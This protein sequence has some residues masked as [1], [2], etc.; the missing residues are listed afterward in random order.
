MENQGTSLSW[1]PR[2]E[3]CQP[4]LT[5]PDR[6]GSTEEEEPAVRS[7]RVRRVG[8]IELLRNAEDFTA[9]VS[10]TPGEEVAM[11]EY[12]MAIMYASECVP[13]T[14]EAWRQWVEEEHS[15]EKAAIWLESRPPEH[16]DLFHPERP[17]GQNALLAPFM[18][19]GGVGSA[20]LVIERTGD[21]NQFFDKVHLHDPEPLPPDAAFRAMLTQHAYGLGGRAMA[22]ADWLGPQLTY[23]AVG[24]LGIRIRVLAR[25]RTL[26]DTLRLNIMPCKPDDVGTFNY[27]WTDGR[28][29]RRTFR[30]RKET[31]LPD[32]PADLHSFLGRSILLRPVLVNGKVM[33]DRV[34]RAAGEILDPLPDVHLQDAVLVAGRKGNPEP[35]RP[36][37]D[38]ALWRESHAVYAATYKAEEEV[39]KGMDL[40]GRLAVLGDRRVDLTAVGLISRQATA[41]AWVSDTFPYVPKWREELKWA[42]DEGSQICEY[43]AKCLYAAAVVARD[44][45]YPNPKPSD[46]AVFLKRLNAEPDLWAGAADHFWFLI[47]EVSGGTRAGK[48]PLAEFGREIHDLTW[49]LLRAR[50]AP[51]LAIPRGKSAGAE[52]E[53]R[54]KKMLASSSCPPYLKERPRV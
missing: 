24:R 51:L 30:G 9:L 42:A 25:G 35:L 28:V 33:V 4:V 45:A 20:Q 54:L 26:G 47:A 50:L 39:A 14:P 29:G 17:L 37:E 46:K 36:S 19:A 7:T 32:G 31:R 48:G 23:Q 40:Y 5:R 2:T 16:W 43:A 13:E 10:S 3:A 6:H 27:S 41:T 49:K 34:L 38:R 21:Y 52:A 8:L 22:K 1:D 18:A 44:K 11:V 15:L 53:L 12:L